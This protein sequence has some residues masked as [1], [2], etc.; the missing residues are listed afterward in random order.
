MTRRSASLTLRAGICAAALVSGTAVSAGEE[1]GT[2]R[3]EIRPETVIAYED[4]AQAQ[5]GLRP[6]ARTM[7]LPAAQW[8]DT[9]Q[10]AS[11]TRA[12]L[13][14][15][16]QNAPG[17]VDVVPADI[18]TWCPGYAD[19]TDQQ[20]RA[21]WVGVMSA[22]SWYESRHQEAVVGA[23]RYF[24]L[25]QIWPTT[26]RGYDCRA[27]TGD[28]LKDGEANLACATRIMA[29]TIER[30]GVVAANQGGLAADWGPM[31]HGWAREEMSEWTRE[32]NYC[33]VD[34]AMSV[35]RPPERPA[36]VAAL[37]TIPGLTATI[38]TSGY[39]TPE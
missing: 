7:A 31:T 39:A 32:Q 19:N 2:T 26:A 28:A 17:I 20:R 36:S 12:T 35:P 14:A 24:G 18:D 3:P 6:V 8:D 22:I 16:E 15:L 9:A 37:A 27:D 1:I 10:G 23:G 13:V 29:V 34:M 38:S 11:W 21:F 5:A 25:M 4:L 33:Q 30:D